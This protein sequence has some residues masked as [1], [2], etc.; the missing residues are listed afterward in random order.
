MKYRGGP[1]VLQ[2]FENPIVG[3]VDRHMDIL[4]HNR[5]RVV[6]ANVTDRPTGPGR[7]SRSAKPFLGTRRRDIWSVIT[8]ESTGHTFATRCALLI[9]TKS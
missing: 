2:F 3:R 8:T 5:R 4:S 7:G 6:H 9:S 1:V